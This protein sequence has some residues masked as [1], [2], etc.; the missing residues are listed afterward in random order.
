MNILIPEVEVKDTVNARQ[1]P[2]SLQDT[3][4]MFGEFRQDV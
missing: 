1:Q 4:F 2:K 3:E